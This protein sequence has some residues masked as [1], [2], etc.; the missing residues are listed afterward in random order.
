MLIKTYGF[1]R[2]FVV[3]FSVGYLFLAYTV[4]TLVSDKFVD[5]QVQQA[6]NSIQHELALVRYSIEANIFR[7]AYL[8]DSFA[9]VVALNPDF[10]MENWEFVSEQFLGKAI[11]VR[12]IG[13]APN[14]I[15]SHVY[16]LKGNEKAIGLD[17]RTVPN[18]YKSVQLAKELKGIIVT[19]PIEL[20]QGGTALIAR[21]P[22][23]TDTPYNTQYWGG[24]SVVI[25]YDKLLK[26]SNLKNIKGTDIA[27]VNNVQERLIEGDKDVLTNYDLS[28]PIYLPN[29]SWTLFAKYD[30]FNEIES[31]SRFNQLFP[32][33]G[34]ITFAIG[35]ILI[36]SLIK[37]YLRIQNLS[38]HDELTGLPNRRY[39]FNELNRIMSRK[40]AVV[41]FTVLNIDLNKFKRINDT[42]GHEV[43][44]R[45]LKHLAR[46]LTKCL[47]SSDFISRVG[48]DEFVII[49]QRTTKSENVEQIIQKIHN[50]ADT[51]PL[52]WKEE[53][54]RLS[55]SVG[56]YVYQ[57]KGDPSQINEI[58]SKADKDMYY[59]KMSKAT[60]QGSGA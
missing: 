43:G 14:D 38:L 46:L 37:N 7:D 47:R 19:G 57:D 49:L 12:N 15:I 11:F 42:L 13:L 22:I 51:H 23:F 27:L 50:Y 41:E 30:D 33:L 32:V 45:V 52:F 55:L 58:L 5:K 44:D 28:F 18:Q 36:L 29:G 24:L 2:W 54:I 17:F 56:Y 34:G 39:L 3:I 60:E 25:N 1:N 21:Y 48:G 53:T 35:Y 31:I 8:A 6:K 9:S 10:A 20:V 4:V 59:A 40:N 26:T 16:P